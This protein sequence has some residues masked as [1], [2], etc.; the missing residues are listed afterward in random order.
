MAQIEPSP[1][2]FPFENDLKAFYADDLDREEGGQGL[3]TAPTMGN[4]IGSNPSIPG[5][6]V[7]PSKWL[8]E[9]NRVLAYLDERK[10]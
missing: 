3:A 4:L 9:S 7:Q 5:W 6:C 1:N 8:T 10:A 2:N